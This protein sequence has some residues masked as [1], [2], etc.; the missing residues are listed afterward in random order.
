VKIKPAPT[1]AATLFGARIAF[2]LARCDLRT[3]AR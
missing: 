1:S 3:A 2:P